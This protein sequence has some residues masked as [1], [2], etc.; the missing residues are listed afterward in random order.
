MA[1]PKWFKKLFFSR[2][3]VITTKK[4]IIPAKTEDFFGKLCEALEKCGEEVIIS[5]DECR[6][7]YAPW[8]ALSPDGPGQI[9]ICAYRAG[10]V[11]ITIPALTS[12]WTDKYLEYFSKK[13]PYRI[14]GPEDLD[15][16]DPEET[17]QRLHEL[18]GEYARVTYEIE[19]IREWAKAE[20]ERA[21]MLKISLLLQT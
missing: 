13:C 19:E 4:R 21:A 3:R 16:A 10:H 14:L 6:P 8:V 2:K 9:K 15:R 17:I 18:A 20:G 1:M 5:K 7:W 12:R 11:E